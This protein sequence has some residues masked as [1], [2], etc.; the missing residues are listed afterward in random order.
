MGVS[1]RNASL[2]VVVVM[3]LDLPRVRFPIIFDVISFDPLLIAPV[4]S[5]ILGCLVAMDR[6]KKLVYIDVR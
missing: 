4:S 3:W 6:G 1:V 5:L 2:M